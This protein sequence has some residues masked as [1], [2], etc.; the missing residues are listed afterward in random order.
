MYCLSR[1]GSAS[2][3]GDDDIWNSQHVRER[4]PSHR[5]IITKNNWN[6][7]NTSK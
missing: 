5:A 2:F 3:P 4:S 7:D 6:A 1:R